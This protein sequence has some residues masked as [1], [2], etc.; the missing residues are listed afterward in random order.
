MDLSKRLT[1]TVTHT[2]KR[3]DGSSGNMG[4]KECF[5]SSGNDQ[6]RLE[7]DIFRTF[8]LFVISRSGVRVRLPAPSSKDARCTSLLA[9]AKS[10]VS[11]PA[12]FLF[13]PQSLRWIASRERGII[14]ASEYG[15]IPEWP[16]G[17]DC[18]SVVSDFGGSNPPSPT[19]NSEHP[20]GWSEF[21]DFRRRWIRKAALSNVPVARC[22]RRGFFRRKSESTFLLWFASVSGDWLDPH[23][24]PHGEMSR[25]R[26]RGYLSY[27]LRRSSLFLCF[28]HITCAMKLPIFSAALSC[29][30]RVTW[31]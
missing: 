26:W 27:P 8:L 12:F 11:A 28:F 14:A 6:K 24:D 2:R 16:K 9:G 29:I 3:V 31:V 19:K 22:N 10:C 4:A 13:A 20:S 5:L 1:H 25:E 23:C 17:A 7:N 21:F 15:G 18:K 30:C